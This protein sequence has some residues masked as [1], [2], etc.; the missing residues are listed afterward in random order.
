MKKLFLVFMFLVGCL[1][2]S[3][4]SEIIN[5]KEPTLYRVE[6]VG[7]DKVFIC[8]EVDKYFNTNCG[9]SINEC[10]VEGEV[11]IAKPILSNLRCVHNIII[12]RLESL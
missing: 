12:T 10:K 9:F 5:Q 7:S 4:K 11:N 1:S 3:E 6:I 8:S 2:E